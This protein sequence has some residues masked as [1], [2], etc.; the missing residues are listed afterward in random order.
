[1]PEQQ[2]NDPRDQQH[3]DCPESGKPQPASLL[4]HH[5]LLLLVTH[6]HFL[7]DIAHTSNNNCNVVRSAPQVGQIDQQPTSLLGWQFAGNCSNF[8]IVEVT[9]QTVGA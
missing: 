9:S 4:L 1:M 3:G 6:E 8:R 2:Q 7:R 5:S